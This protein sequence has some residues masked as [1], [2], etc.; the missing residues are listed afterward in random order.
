MSDTEGQ[1]EDYVCSQE[2][3]AGREFYGDGACAECGY[4]PPADIRKYKLGILV[5]TESALMAKDILA[6]IEQALLAVG[7]RPSYAHAE[8]YFPKQAQFT[9]IPEETPDGPQ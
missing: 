9:T 1:A 2:P 5:E 8:Q 4:K 6:T 7:V 3:H